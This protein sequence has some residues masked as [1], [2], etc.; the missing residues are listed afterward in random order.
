MQ[1]VLQTLETKALHWFYA[2]RHSLQGFFHQSS[3]IRQIFKDI[4]GHIQLEVNYIN[5]SVL[6]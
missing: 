2:I 5:I 6:G 1:I 3:Q 4:K